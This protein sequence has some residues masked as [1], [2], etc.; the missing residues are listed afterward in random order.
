MLRFGVEDVRDN[1]RRMIAEI[2]AA[3]TRRRSW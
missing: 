2:R 3:I 1:P